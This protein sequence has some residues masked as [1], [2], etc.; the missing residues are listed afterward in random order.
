MGELPAS[1]ATSG[2]QAAP[3]REVATGTPD[4][5]CKGDALE[6]VPQPPSADDNTE[7]A[8][9]GL[10]EAAAKDG[11][12]MHE[13]VSDAAEQQQANGRLPHPPPFTPPH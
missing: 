4:P 1:G 3:E 9:E 5:E 2:E 10:E 6:G 12:P 13:A 7:E 8:K 11:S